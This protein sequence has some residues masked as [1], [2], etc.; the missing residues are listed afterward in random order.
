M[1]TA[2]NGVAA[3]SAAPPEMPAPAQAPVN[4]IRYEHAPA[5]THT[6]ALVHVCYARERIF[7]EFRTCRADAK[8]G[9]RAA[10]VGHSLDPTTGFPRLFNL[11]TTFPWHLR[12][13]STFLALHFGMLG[14]FAL[15]LLGYTLLA[16]W[17]LVDFVG[18]A[19]Y[20]YRFR[21]E[22][23]ES[24]GE[25]NVEFCSDVFIDDD[26]TQPS[27]LWKEKN[28]LTDDW[29]RHFHTFMWPCTSMVH[30]STPRSRPL[31]KAVYR[32][33]HISPIHVRVVSGHLCVDITTSCL[34]R[35][36]LSLRHR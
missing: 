1:K 30:L 3:H 28:Y 11:F 12:R 8:S 13:H 31:Q 20:R 10:L 19:N 5:A 36:L 23:E 26:Q 22:V 7:E 32:A 27:L 18:G 15:L 4:A 33:L 29:V 14:L 35:L 2:D 34:Y 17:P 24:P 16:L 9:R 25:W 21:L 6:L